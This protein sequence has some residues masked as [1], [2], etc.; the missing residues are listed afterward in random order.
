M[1]DDTVVPNP[2]QP[3]PQPEEAVPGAAPAAL[4]QSAQAAA[5]VEAAASEIPP[6]APGEAEKST[7][8][9]DGQQATE[10][11]A[12]PSEASDSAVPEPDLLSVL[13]ADLAR[14]TAENQK[15]IED[16]RRVTDEH[17]QLHLALDE[18]RAKLAAQAAP[19][20]LSDASVARLK[21]AVLEALAEHALTEAAPAEDHPPAEPQSPFISRA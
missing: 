10:S 21:Q 13:Q 5:P 19:V 14:L 18:A 3:A 12:S 16:I 15:L 9:A 2:I 1:P 17:T 20:D 6:E 11:P 8:D 4:A 7:E